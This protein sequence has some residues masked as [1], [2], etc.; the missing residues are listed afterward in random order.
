MNGM[1][2]KYTVTVTSVQIATSLVSD[3]RGE[4][5]GIIS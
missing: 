5:A 4:E 3:L 2:I 1:N